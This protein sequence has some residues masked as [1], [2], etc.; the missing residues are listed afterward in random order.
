VN[1]GREIELL[2]PLGTPIAVIS[3]ASLIGQENVGDDLM[4][5]DW[6]S[7]KV[8]STRE[9]A[10]RHINRP[11]PSLRLSS[12]LDGMRSFAGAFRGELVVE[13]ML[14]KGFNDDEESIEELADFL[15][16][17]RPSKAYLSIPTRPPALRSAEP[18]DEAHVLR[19]Y[20][21]LSDRVD[22]VECLLGYEGNR[23]AYGG[24]VAEDL[25]GIT[26]VHPMREDAVLDLLSRADADWS[27]VAR[28]LASGRLA[29]TDYRGSRFYMRVVPK[30][31][32]M[33]GT[34]RV[35]AE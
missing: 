24:D 26:A 20:S 34:G 18:P 14:V 30:S 9:A 21:L 5:A 29:Q 2:R 27:V 33:A 15:A 11:H 23:F 10:W 13:T 8:D 16:S 28:L 25:L 35:A 1:L 7:L 32:R 12:I 19:A 4:R 3:N 6:V 31:S 22:S 17:L